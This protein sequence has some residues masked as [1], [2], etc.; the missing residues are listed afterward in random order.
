MS[1]FW[2]I[3]VPLDKTSLTNIEKLKRSIIKTNQASCC[4][5]LIPDL[6]VGILDSLVSVSDDLS[7]LDTLTESVLKKI[8]QCMKEVME[9]SCDKKLEK[10]LANGEHMNEKSHVSPV[11]SYFQS[12]Q[13]DLVAYVTRFQWDKAK[14][15]TSLPL[16]A[17]TDIIHK[18][19]ALV[20]T[21]LKSRSSSYNSLKSN[22]QNLESKHQGSLQ[23]RC[24]N[25]FV[26]KEDLVVSEYLTTLL[27]IVNRRSFDQWE[28]TYESLSDFVVPRSSRRLYEDAEAGIFS[29]TL[30]KRAVSQ[31]KAKA[32]ESKFTVREYHVELE[33]Q[34]LRDL[35]T[36]RAQRKEQRG[37]FV[38]WLKVNFRQLFVSWIH[39]KALRVFVESVLRYGLPVNFQALLLQMDKKRSKQMREELA[40][41]F[42]HLD[43]SAM[44]TKTEVSCDLPGLCLQEYFS[45]ISVHINTTVLELR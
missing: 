29:V 20:E 41:L 43:P 32:Q 31:F 16:S 38:C 45:Y 19:V 9:F 17:L 1:D 11:E 7:G 4:K 30:F 10:S 2:L 37:I 12:L 28:K 27:V 3:S 34:Q 22:L 8:G 42:V 36:L 40:S 33:E 14:F 35:Q 44:T 23:S 13:V 25:N 6:K 15:S 39:L 18:E 24:L 5:F 21:E 26:R